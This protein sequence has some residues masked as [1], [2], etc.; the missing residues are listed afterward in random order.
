MSIK[1]SIISS[2][3]TIHGEISSTGALEINGAVIDHV[4]AKRLYIG[5]QG[6]VSGD[7]YA[8]F[9]EVAGCI[10][11]HLVAAEVRIKPTARILSD[12]CYHQLDIEQGALVHGL[13]S[14]TE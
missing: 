5:E 2:T 12:M 13:I 9:I 11:G 6:A 10:S 1:T 14:Q 4:Q 8:G 7:V 3:L